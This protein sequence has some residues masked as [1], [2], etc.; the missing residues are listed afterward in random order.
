LQAVLVVVVA[1][2]LVGIQLRQI[3]VA[4]GELAVEDEDAAVRHTVHRAMAK[5]LP[6][7][8]QDQVVAVATLTHQGVAVDHRA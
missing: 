1:V 5:M 2:V 8:I 6:A 3:K 7:T 4:L